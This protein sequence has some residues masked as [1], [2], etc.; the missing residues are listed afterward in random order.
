MWDKFFPYD[1]LHQAE[2]LTTAHELAHHMQFTLEA[3]SGKSLND[4]FHYSTNGCTED[5][6][7]DFPDYMR[8][9]FD[10]NIFP[11]QYVKKKYMFASERLTSVV[12]QEYQAEM[13]ALSSEEI[14]ETTEN[15]YTGNI[16]F[17]AEY[18]AFFDF[19]TL[20]MASH[21]NPDVLDTLRFFGGSILYSQKPFDFSVEMSR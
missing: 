10:K 4:V 5:I 13:Y 21:G 7:L 12:I 1:H 9:Q 6:E 17:L 18:G 16:T 19:Q 2:R 14:R 11:T 20:I 8:E 3:I 15:E